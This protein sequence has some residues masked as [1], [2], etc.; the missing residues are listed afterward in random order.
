MIPQVAMST[1][2]LRSWFLNLNPYKKKPWFPGK[3]GIS[4]TL[5]GKVQGEPGTSLSRQQRRHQRLM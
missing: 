5:T 1:P 4:R 3:T 2:D